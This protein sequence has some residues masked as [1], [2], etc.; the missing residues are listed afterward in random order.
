MEMANDDDMDVLLAPT[1]VVP[2]TLAHPVVSKPVHPRTVM[3]DRLERLFTQG[4]ELASTLLH[5]EENIDKTG[6]GLG[7]THESYPHVGA[8]L[9][10]QTGHAPGC[11][12]RPSPCSI[13]VLLITR[14][15]RR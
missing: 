3:E 6:I 2:P 9:A 5:P 12:G 11:F 4:R 14:L 10:F 7:G 13:C 1:I 8:R 15:W